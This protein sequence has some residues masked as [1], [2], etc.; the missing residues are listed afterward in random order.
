M[1]KSIFCSSCKVP[2]IL[3]IFQRKLNVPDIFSKNVEV[4]NFLKVLSPGDLLFNA[5]RRTD[6][7][8]LIFA[9]RNFANALESVPRLRGKKKGGIIHRN[10]LL[11]KKTSISLELDRID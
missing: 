5:D 11:Y 7:T 8:K 10:V 1:I 6:M 2:V 9:F 4:P 3:V